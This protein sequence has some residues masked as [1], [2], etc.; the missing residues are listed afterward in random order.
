MKF[1]KVEIYN[2]LKM[3]EESFVVE[4]WEGPSK[5]AQI[6]AEVH[7]EYENIRVKKTK[8]PKWVKGW[9]Q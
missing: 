8:K 4:Y 9:G 2:R 1:W 7:P 5:I 6:L 3:K